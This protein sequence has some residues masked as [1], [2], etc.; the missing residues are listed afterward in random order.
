MKPLKRVLATTSGVAFGL[1]GAIGSAGLALTTASWLVGG[2]N[3]VSQLFDGQPG[4]GLGAVEMIVLAASLAV[5]FGIGLSL[6]TVASTRFGWLS[7]DEI[8]SLLGR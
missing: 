7:M 3:R 2:T 8:R 6:W 5:G 1:L 4:P